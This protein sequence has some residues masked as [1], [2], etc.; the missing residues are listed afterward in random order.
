MWSNRTG[1]AQLVMRLDGDGLPVFSAG[2]SY[3]ELVVDD[4]LVLLAEPTRPYA[5]PWSPTAN[6]HGNRRSD[7]E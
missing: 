7:A 6:T 1:Y 5:A 3:T 2:S 4:W